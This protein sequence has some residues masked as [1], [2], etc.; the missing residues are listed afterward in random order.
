MREGNVTGSVN[1]PVPA[2]TCPLPSMIGPDQSTVTVRE[3][4]ISVSSRQSSG[5]SRQS[6]PPVISPVVSA[7]SPFL[8]LPRSP[9]PLNNRADQAKDEPHG[10]HPALARGGIRR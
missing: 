6:H 10:D 8:G 4:V 2:F 1:A 9:G 5:G 7:C 3:K